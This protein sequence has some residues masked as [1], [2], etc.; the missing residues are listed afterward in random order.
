MSS[1]FNMINRRE[2]SR[3]C[4]I[5]QQ[6]KQRFGLFSTLELYTCLL[7]PNFGEFVKATWASKI[8]C[9]KNY[10]KFNFARTFLCNSHL[11]APIYLARRA[12]APP[13]VH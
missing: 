1:I 4:V 10:T 7:I 5:R 6:P 9:E 2:N 11:G 3:W 13:A 12:A 8:V